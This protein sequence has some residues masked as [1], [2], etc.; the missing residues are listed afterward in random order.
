MVQIPQKIGKQ[1][2]PID[3][4]IILESNVS[5]IKVEEG[6]NVKLVDE[7]IGYGNKKV[8]IVDDNILNIKVA[9]RALD[10][11]DFEIDECENGQ[12][13]L[14]KIRSGNQYD[15]ILMDIMMPVM[16]GE[17]AIKYLKEIEGFNTPVVALTAD[18]VAGARE[19][20]LEEGFIDYIAKPFSRDQ[21]KEKLDIIFSKKTEKKE[22]YQS[23]K[24]EKV[25]AYVIYIYTHI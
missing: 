16:S 4:S 21:I 19:K 5:G 15:L 23:Y 9:R 3:E 14:D 18:A 22:E 10:S 11:F 17:T 20:Y 6:K 12:I 25:P 13:C 8:L 1:S 2:A 7:Y 24:W